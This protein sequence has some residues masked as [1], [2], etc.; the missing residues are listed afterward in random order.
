MTTFNLVYVEAVEF[1]VLFFDQI[2]DNLVVIRPIQQ[3][4]IVLV[5]SEIRRQLM[6]FNIVAAT[7]LFF[8]FFALS[9]ITQILH[10]FA[11]HLLMDLRQI[12]E[13]LLVF[14]FHV[15]EVAEADQIFLQKVQHV[16]SFGRIVVFG[17]R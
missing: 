6:S 9:D 8:L 1:F 15:F 3:T 12:A 7:G 13:I 2:H 16:V 10:F 4:D 14:L 11:E 5:L 17:D